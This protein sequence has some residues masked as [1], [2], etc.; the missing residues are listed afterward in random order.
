MHGSNSVVKHL[1]VPQK[2]VGSNPS[3]DKTFLEKSMIMV[4]PSSG[5]SSHGLAILREISL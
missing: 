5:Q 1:T 2:V 3:K 4:V